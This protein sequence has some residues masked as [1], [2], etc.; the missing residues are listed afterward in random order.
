MTVYKFKQE[1]L[2][3][4]IKR[5]C[6]LIKL[7]KSVYYDWLAKGKPRYKCIDFNFL[8]EVESSFKTNGR[9]YGVR[10][11]KTLL[12]TKFSYKKNFKSYE[13]L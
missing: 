1:N 13:V 6:Y 3:L 4:F 12:K 9:I 11:I 10:R 5:L 8:S 2:D 7:P